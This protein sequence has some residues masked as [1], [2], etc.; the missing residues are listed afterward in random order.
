M[1]LI[2]KSAV[3]EKRILFANDR[4]KHG[5]KFATTEGFNCV[6]Q[7]NM[8]IIVL[9]KLSLPA[10]SMASHIKNQVGKQASGTCYRL[11][12]EA[13]RYLVKVISTDDSHYM[14]DMAKVEMLLIGLRKEEVPRKVEPDKLLLTC[15]DIFMTL[16]TSFSQYEKVERCV[17][18]TGWLLQVRVVQWCILGPDRTQ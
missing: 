13:L 9:N 1:K 17:N 3:R 6:V 2:K 14:H 7:L 11:K 10:H 8:I 5:Q 15:C 4:V 18:K 16:K 12:D